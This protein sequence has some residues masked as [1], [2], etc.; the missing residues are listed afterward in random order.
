MGLILILID[1]H[2]LICFVFFFLFVFPKMNSEKIYI[3]FNK[4]QIKRLAFDWERWRRT[5]GQTQPFTDSRKPY[6]QLTTTQLNR[7]YISEK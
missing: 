3:I 7:R 6:L 5:I 2:A 1:I 4:A